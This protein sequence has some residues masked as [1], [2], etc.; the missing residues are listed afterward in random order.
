M[1]LLVLRGSDN[2]WTHL[3]PRSKNSRP[4]SDYG[5]PTPTTSCY[6]LLLLTLFHELRKPLFNPLSDLFV[7][8]FL[9]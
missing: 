4:L 8:P 9:C 1:Y 3:Y 2:F 5:A 7:T 6:L